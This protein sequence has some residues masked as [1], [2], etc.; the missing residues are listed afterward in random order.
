MEVFGTDNFY[1]HSVEVIRCY[2][3]EI[4]Q[5]DLLISVPLANGQYIFSS[6]IWLTVNDAANQNRITK[7]K[8]TSGPT[9]PDVAET[10]NVSQAVSLKNTRGSSTQRNASK[11]PLKLHLLCHFTF[12]NLLEKNA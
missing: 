1:S 2:I 11:A 6:C 9:I 3:L 10:V 8:T 4:Y 12:K 7:H 5:D